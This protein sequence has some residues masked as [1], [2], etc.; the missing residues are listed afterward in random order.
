MMNGRTRGG[1]MERKHRR[2]DAEKL[3]ED[4]RAVKAAYKIGGYQ[5]ALVEAALRGLHRAAAKLLV[6]QV[7]AEI[8]QERESNGK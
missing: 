5:T 4:R 8:K 2:E 3:A 1:L 6:D 7:E